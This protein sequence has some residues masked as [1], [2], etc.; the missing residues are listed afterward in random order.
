[1]QIQASGA[2]VGGFPSYKRE[3]MT[4]EEKTRDELITEI[5]ELRRQCSSLEDAINAQRAG[6]NSCMYRESF[7]QCVFRHVPT[8]T[9]LI[10]D[11]VIKDADSALCSLLGYTPDELLNRKWSIL[12][13]TDADYDYVSDELHRQIRGYGTGTI[14]TVMQCKNGYIRNVLV[15]LYPINSADLL[16]GFTLIVR[17]I[18]DWKKSEKQIQESDNRYAALIE[19]IDTGVA[20]YDAVDDGRDFIF[21]A[22]NPAAERIVHLTGAQVVGKT[23]LTLFPNMG[24]TVLPAALCRVWKT[25]RTEHLAPFYYQDDI[26]QGWRENHIY[27][28]PSGEIV[29]LFDDVTERKQIEDSLR[30]SEERFRVL[31]ENIRDGVFVHPMV[32]P[33]EPGKF[34][35]VNPSA[36]DTLGYTKEELLGMGPRELDDAESSVA[37]IPEAMKRLMEDGCVLFEAVQR[38]RKGNRI[39]VEVNAN[40]VELSGKPYIVSSVRD[41]TLRKQHENKLLESTQFLKSIYD[42]VNNSVFVVDVQQDGSYRYKGI[43]RMH[44]ILTGIK[45][46]EITGKSPDEIIAAPFAESVIRHYDACIQSGSTI[47]YEELLPF[48]GRETYWETVLTPVRDNVGHIYRIIGTSTDIT[49]RKISEQRLRKLSVAVEQSPAVVVITD[50]MGNIEYVNPKF[51]QLTGYTVREA[52]GNNPNILQSGLTPRETFYELWDTILSGGVW[53]GELYNRKKNGDIYIESAVISPIFN[54]EGSITNF[55]AV[56]EDIT[57]KKKLWSELIAAKEK[58]EESD[59][60]KTA[61]LANISHEIRTPMNGILGFSELLKEPHLSGEEQTEYINL[62]NQSGQRMLHL[63]NELVDISRIESGDTFLQITETSINRLMHDIYAFFRPEAAKKGLLFECIVGLSDLFS[64]IDTDS[65]KVNQILTNLVQNALKFTTEGSVDFR[66]TL[67]NDCLEFYVTDSGACIPSEMKEKIFDRFRQVDNSLTRRYEGAGL[68]LSISK[69]YIEM[70]GGKI[71]VESIEGRGNRFV[72]TLQY[73]PS[74]S[75]TMQ[76][77]DPDFQGRTECF[78]NLTILIAEDD[79]VSS[80]LLQRNLKGEN[81]TILHARN[82]Q[83]AVEQVQKNS[84]IRLVLMDIQ[85]PV[86]NGF[87]A[88]REIKAL[89]PGLPVIA[90]TAFTSKEEKEKTKEAGCDGFITK[91]VN[92]IELLCLMESLLNPKTGD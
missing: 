10:A 72:F 59:R 76:Q 4:D 89:R 9:G 1:L 44:E 8:G 63:I 26:R 84:A 19:N 22:L 31:F 47:Q 45:N 88:T 68:G 73:K 50:Y 57:E 13:T 14:E 27:K 92:K 15:S 82:G 42:G 12:Y 41:I 61:F 56:K 70:L 43:N 32:T 3:A 11:S 86:M 78:S 5:E 33:S 29:A 7:V 77:F 60:L 66:Y 54:K 39:P 25:G 81:I 71:W 17:D 91:P 37:Y 2:D 69:A 64:V 24:S 53:H 58:A 40:I 74:T 18:T 83:D 80:L 16:L 34:A 48:K 52:V 28:I 23:L 90:Q 67:K 62:I 46:E 65:S 79:E 35:M 21:K 6:W 38:D 20:V 75:V 87:D 49:K 55:V 36:C 85:M 51:T 30:E